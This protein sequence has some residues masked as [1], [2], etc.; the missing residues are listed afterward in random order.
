MK[1]KLLEIFQLCLD[2]NKQGQYKIIFDYGGFSRIIGVSVFIGIDIDNAINI[3]Y[4]SIDI[5]AVGA[6][7]KIDSLISKLQIFKQTVYA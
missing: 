5:S 1:T 4:K 3:Y 7:D 2:I 6:M